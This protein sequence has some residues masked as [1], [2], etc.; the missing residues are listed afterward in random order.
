MEKN[1]EKKLLQNKILDIANLKK[2][3]DMMLN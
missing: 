2:Y 1:R 3:F